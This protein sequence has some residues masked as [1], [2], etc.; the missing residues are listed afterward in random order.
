MALFRKQSQRLRGKRS[1]EKPQRNLQARNQAHPLSFEE[2]LCSRG[3]HGEKGLEA[4]AST[5]KI[6]AKTPKIGLFA[7]VT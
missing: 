4:Q 5:F 2:V 1:P 7:Q 3:M 6:Q